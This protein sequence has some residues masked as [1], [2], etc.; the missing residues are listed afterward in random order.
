MFTRHLVQRAEV[1]HGP[2]PVGYVRVVDPDSAL[3]E[4]LVAVTDGLELPDTLNRILRIALELSGARYAALGVLGADGQLT[5]FLHTGMSEAT[6][7]GIANPPTGR[8]LL[9]EVNKA[10]RPI[11]VADVADHP[12]SVG[13][14]EGHPPMASFLGV[15]IV[16]RGRTFGRLYL[17]EKPGGFDADDEKRITTLAAAAG[18]AVEN[19][20]L[21]VTARS[22]AMHQS[23]VAAMTRAALQEDGGEV[24]QLL[25]DS[26]RALSAASAAAVVTP[27]GQ[28]ALI[29]VVSLPGAANGIDMRLAQPGAGV[30]AGLFGAVTPA[31]APP[32]GSLGEVSRTAAPL[33]EAGED[34]GTF[35][36]VTPAPAPLR[37]TGEDAGALGAVTPASAPLTGSGEDA[38]SPLASDI[39]AYPTPRAVADRAAT[40]P[41]AAIRADGVV[42][43]A[44]SP[45][46][47]P[48]QDPLR[49]DDVEQAVLGWM[50]TRSAG[51]P[52]VECLRI[53]QPVIE[54][55]YPP[56]LG[57]T[58]GRIGC[59]PIAEAEG[60]GRVFGL[61]V[62]LWREPGP[63]G[64]PTPGTATTAT[65]AHA[66]VVA[67]LTDHAA[68]ALLLNDARQ[69]EERLVVFQDRD[70]IARD[71]HDLVVQRLFASGMSLQV[72]N[73]T[74]ELSAESRKRID[75]V[76]GDI[77]ATIAQI[78]ETIFELREGLTNRR[79][80][81]DRLADEV[82][83]MGDALGFSPQLDVSAELTDVEYDELV[84]DCVAVTCEGLSNTA[85]HAGASQ[86]RVDVVTDDSGLRISVVDD[87]RGP[88]DSSRR[89]GLANLQRRAASH[90]GS[91]ALQ[92]APDGGS[93]LRWCVPLPRG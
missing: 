41:A 18:V 47:S 32:P 10:G 39:D 75:G 61:L 90:G 71:L 66:D 77:D 13:F 93:E 85:R 11:R 63:A 65:V 29:E 4:A 38:A 12:A 42:A 20:Q 86:V 56:G 15:P 45:A 27:Q 46:P 34:A 33:R 89:S 73:R 17:T 64:P 70:R 74:A 62:L 54:S 58:H 57:S 72:L 82:E 7:A 3:S 91:C 51:R 44:G 80:L 60:D 59:F 37:E 48:V 36:A 2:C 40:P 88:G 19:A 23:A 35:G 14:P 9:G 79:R 68:T 6:V 16:V 78:R 31:P 49:R 28:D 55:D 53:R 30:D 1:G 21:F 5:Q 50:R 76:V 26:A 81:A 69:A 52:L 22:G 8:G 87:G 43:A 83:L 24:L 84:A 92:P 25:A 67:S